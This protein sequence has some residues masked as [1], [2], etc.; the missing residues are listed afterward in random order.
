MV[1]R[2]LTWAVVAILFGTLFAGTRAEASRR[3]CYNGGRWSHRYHAGYHRYYGGP[4]VGFY[5]ASAPVYVVRDYPDSYRCRDRYYRDDRPSFSLSINLGGGR[6]GHY[7]R[8]RPSSYRCRDYG[9]RDSGYRDHVYAR[10][11]DRW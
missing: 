2:S 10:Y 8:Y 4:S 5:Y 9:R 6:G 3:Y 11:S 1:R 7:A